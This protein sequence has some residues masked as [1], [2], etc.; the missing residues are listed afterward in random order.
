M[1]ELD[2]G[3]VIVGIGADGDHS[4]NACGLG[5]SKD[6]IELF[7]ESRIG[8]MAVRVDHSS[9]GFQPV[10]WTRAGSPCY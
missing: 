9:T 8:E 4:I 6:V 1:T 10:T 5:A 2:G 7:E 3:Q